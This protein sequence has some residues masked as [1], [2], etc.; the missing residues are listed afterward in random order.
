MTYT[1]DDVASTLNAIQPYDWAG[2]LRQRLTETGKPAPV[3]GFAMNGYRLVY[4]AEPTLAYRGAERAKGTDVSYSLGLVIDKDAVVT[5]TIW[6]GPAF[7]AGF[8]VGVTVLA[9]NGDAYTGDRLK[10][11][12]VAAK[13]TTAP[14][15]L[16]IK[17]GQRVRQIAVD[18]H[19]GPRYPR[20]E[21][22][23]TGDAG[24]DRL[25]APR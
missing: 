15:Q 21:R 25:L 20:L 18:Y 2:F 16:T 24:L 8:K 22:T 10:A 14:I 19:D 17:D 9:V 13:G 3:N 1:F 23:G 4:T 11:A 6:N 12:I 5:Q 7:K